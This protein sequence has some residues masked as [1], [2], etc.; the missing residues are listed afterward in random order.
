MDTFLETCG[1]SSN[2]EAAVRSRSPFNLTHIAPRHAAHSTNARRLYD[3]STRLSC[4]TNQQ[5]VQAIPPKGAT[6][7]VNRVRPS[8][9][10]R[11]NGS[12]ALHPGD[13]N[14]LGAGETPELVANAESIEQPESRGRETLTADFPTRRHVLFN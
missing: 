1:R 13:L 11:H 2:R 12:I 4:P 5:V 7:R 6:V 10:G 9:Q 14:Q 8:R 3:F